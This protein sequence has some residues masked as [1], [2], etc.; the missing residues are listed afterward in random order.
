M[1]ADLLCLLWTKEAAESGFVRNEWLTARA[2]EKP[3]LPCLFLDAPKLPK[4][5]ENLQGVFL[6]GERKAFRNLLDRVLSRI[7]VPAEYDFRAPPVR[8][9]VPFSPDNHFTGREHDLLALYVAMVGQ[10]NKIGI[11][12]LGVVGMG[13]LGKTELVVEFAHRFGFA[14]DGVYWV[15][16]NEPDQLKAN[17]VGLARDVLGLKI[18]HP[19]RRDASANFLLKLLAYSKVHP[20]MLVII[21]NV[22]DPN[23][24][25][26]PGVLPGGKF[27]VLDLGCNL[28]FTTRQQFRLTGVQQQILDPLRPEAAYVLLT[29]DRPQGLS[30]EEAGFAQDICNAVGYLPLALALINAYLRTYPRI[31]YGQYLAILRRSNLGAIDATN[32]G[33]NELATRHEAA[34]GTTLRSQW[35][36]LRSQDARLVLRIAAQFP[37]GTIVPANRI[38]LLAGL[39][40]RNSEMEVPLARAINMLQQFSLIGTLENLSAVRVHPLVSEFVRNLASKS[41]RTALLNTG[42]SKLNAAYQNPSRLKNEYEDRGIDQVI[43]DLEIAITWSEGDDALRQRLGI[44]RRLLDRERSN[45]RPDADQPPELKARIFQQL[46]Q[47]AAMMG[48]PEFAAMF[49]RAGLSAGH[50]MLRVRAST[51]IEDPGH[52]PNVS[53]AA[54]CSDGGIHQRVWPSILLPGR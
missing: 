32:I 52:G 15:Q 36:M 23:I 34:I 27:G 33:P 51:A 46:H 28:L 25:V 41:A 30:G 54:Q 17:L 48:L 5:I 13:G 53:Q 19:D 14:F 40:D 20:Q 24:L 3:I 16:G 9:H 6:K 22:A 18:S 2:L 38:G 8:G 29:R 44:L 50:T 4:P 7:S 47:R 49:L 10:L 1:Q 37:E 43:S 45:L 21:D 26:D 35:K 39:E 42:A 31:T 12:R 11:S